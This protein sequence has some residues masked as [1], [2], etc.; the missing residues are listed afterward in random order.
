M[1]IKGELLVNES[2]QNKEK[3]ISKGRKYSG[4]DKHGFAKSEMEI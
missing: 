1:I 3:G 4:E 2:Q